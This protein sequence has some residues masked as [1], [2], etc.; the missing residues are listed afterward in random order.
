MLLVLGVL[1]LALCALAF[2]WALSAYRQP[3]RPGW[4]RREGNGA[5][6][7]LAIMLLGAL[8]LGFLLKFGIDFQTQT[9]TLVEVALT[10]AILAGAVVLGRRLRSVIR[11]HRLAPASAPR[12]VARGRRTV[13]AGR[14]P[15]TSGRSRSHRRKAA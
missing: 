9:F 10:A 5:Y 3:D 1:L 4:T 2:L 8:G 12:V 7:T 11:Q 6:L 13:A 15:H 14:A